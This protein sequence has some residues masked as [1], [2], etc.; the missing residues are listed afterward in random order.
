MALLR[1]F[2]TE[3]G[4]AELYGRSVDERVAALIAISDPR[5]R[6]ELEQAVREVE[7]YFREHSHR[8]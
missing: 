8:S 7:M 5:F 4:V 1:R 6:P 2:A 3:H